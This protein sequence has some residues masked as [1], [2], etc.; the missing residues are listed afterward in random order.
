MA[1]APFWLG[2]GQ[3]L[4]ADCQRLAVLLVLAGQD[5]DHGEIAL[6]AGMK[7]LTGDQLIDRVPDDLF[8]DLEAL[9]IGVV[10]ICWGQR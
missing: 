9:V 5:L 2:L 6:L 3:V 4:D 1:R 8:S 7:D 10:G